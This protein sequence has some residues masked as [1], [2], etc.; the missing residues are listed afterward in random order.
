[1]AYPTYLG[2]AC[3]IGAGADYTDINVDYPASSSGDL[4]IMMVHGA[5]TSSG[6]P[7]DYTFNGASWNFI[8]EHT[9]S[10]TGALRYSYYWRFRGAETSVQIDSGN[11]TFNHMSGCIVAYAGASVDPTTPVGTGGL[12]YNVSSSTGG[13]V[14]PSV[15]TQGADAHVLCFS[16]AIRNATS[17]TVTTTWGGATERFDQQL[18][19][20]SPTRR[21]PYSVATAER[22]TAGTTSTYSASW[23]AASAGRVVA[24]IPVHSPLF[25]PTL[26]MR[27]GTDVVQSIYAGTDLVRKVY[28]GDSLVWQ[29]N[30]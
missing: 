23:S 6:L 28:V 18:V 4:L 25:T 5:R 20:S 24:A 1:M 17:G 8:M 9:D 13:L 30:P 26:K 29:K 27:S 2:A 15:V 12:T 22:P 7:D 3:D 10:A 16:F 21:Y 11:P 14:T 19:G